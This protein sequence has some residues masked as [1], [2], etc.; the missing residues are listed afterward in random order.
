MALLALLATTLAVGCATPDTV[1]SSQESTD[2]AGLGETVVATTIG[3][4]PDSEATVGIAS[5]TERSEAI[6]EGPSLES[7]AGEGSTGPPST[8]SSGG[9]F[10]ADPQARG[11]EGYGA[12]GILGVRYGVHEDY[13]RVVIDLGAG[14]QPAGSAPEWVLSSPTG[15]GVLRVTVPSVSMTRVSD[16]AFSGPLLKDFHVVRAPEGGM[17]VDIFAESAFTYRVTELLDPARIVVD[18]KPSEATLDLPLPAESA[19]TILVEPRRGTRVDNSLTIS[20]YSRNPEASN[21]LVLTDAAGQELV[22]DTV[23]SNDW[24][25]TWGYF[26][27]TLDLPPFSGRATLK[28][29]AESARDGTFEGVEIPVF[30]AG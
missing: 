30:G 8:Q 11:G 6:Q 7:S 26:E 3:P 15:D 4:A 27:T 22:R 17:F 25:A 16:G 14:G 24:T 23:M 21:T 1:S 29:G 18:F 5:T 2:E 20:G 12:D 19:N 10:V 13:E 9:P 28:V